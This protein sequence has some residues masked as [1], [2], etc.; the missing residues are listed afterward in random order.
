MHM[1]EAIRSTGLEKS[2][3]FYQ[4]STSELYGKVCRIHSIDMLA[5]LGSLRELPRSGSVAGLPHGCCLLI[6]CI[7]ALVH[8][9][10]GPTSGFRQP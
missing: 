10:T 2:T 5:W 9:L 3:R 6:P 8:A 7:P 4:A 1:L